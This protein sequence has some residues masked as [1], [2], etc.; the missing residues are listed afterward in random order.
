MVEKTIPGGK[1]FNN[2]RDIFGVIPVAK[3]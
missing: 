2:A 3:V 1:Y